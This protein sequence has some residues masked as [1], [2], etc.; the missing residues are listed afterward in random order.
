MVYF[1]ASQQCSL[2]MVRLMQRD[3]QAQ[4]WKAVSN[5]IH[6]T[7]SLLQKLPSYRHQCRYN[8]N[9]APSKDGLTPGVKTDPVRDPA[10][11]AVSPDQKSEDKLKPNALLEGEQLSAK[12]QRTADWAILKEMSAY[13]WPKVRSFSHSENHHSIGAER[14]GS[15]KSSGHCSWSAGSLKGRLFSSMV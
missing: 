7:A 10:T 6:P 1:R 14:P 15:A 11:P 5:R 8:S 2:S 13:L 4:A 9:S 3:L 12:G